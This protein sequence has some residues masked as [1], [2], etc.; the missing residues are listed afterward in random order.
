MRAR[1]A[2]RARSRGWRSWGNEPPGQVAGVGREPLAGVADPTPGGAGLLNVVNHQALDRP[3]KHVV[4][5]QDVEEPNERLRQRGNPCSVLSLA[6]P[7][8]A[9]EDMD[10]R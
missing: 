5:K 1:G 6:L 10:D 7:R 9:L 8:D 3:G 2:C 4:P